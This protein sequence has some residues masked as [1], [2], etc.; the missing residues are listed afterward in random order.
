MKKSFLTGLVILL[1]IAVT[2]A[3]L[4]FIINF[5]TAPFVEIVSSFILKYCVAQNGFL[6]L[7]QEQVIRYLSKLLILILLFF[8]ILFLG[9]IARMYALRSILYFGDR[10]LKK[11]PIV[12][13]VYKTTQEIIKTFFSPEKTTFRK[14]VLVPFPRPGMYTLGLVSGEAPRVLSDTLQSHL[15]AVLILTTPNP[16]TGYLLMYKPE[17]VIYLDLKPEEA[18]K[19]ILSCGVLVPIERIT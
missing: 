6:F 8:V 2:L 10:I 13:T 9:T 12:N 11:I 3:I 18:I 1:P 7:T 14:V 5:F 16:S 17:D 19:Y 4:G 15:V